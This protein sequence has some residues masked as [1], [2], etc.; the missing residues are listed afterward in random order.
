MKSGVEQFEGDERFESSA[1]IKI[2]RAPRIRD[3]RVRVSA[4]Q[5]EKGK[6]KCDAANVATRPPLR[7][8][9]ASLLG[10]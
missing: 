10:K 7:V 8:G 9:A 2:Q 6:L 1:G 5:R 4:L 3:S